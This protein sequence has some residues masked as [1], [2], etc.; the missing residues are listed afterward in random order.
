M[1][2]KIDH[3]VRK[4]QM[5]RHPFGVVHIIEGAAA[6]LR[7]TRALQFRQAPLIPQ[8]HSEADHAP[9]LLLQKSGYGGAVHTARHSHGHDVR[10]CRR[11]CRQCFE[12]C[13]RVHGL[14]FIHQHSL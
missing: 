2:F 11:R 4:I 12:L 3:V 1:L 10:L 6:M 13:F 14:I 9:A 7:R 8:L 5:L